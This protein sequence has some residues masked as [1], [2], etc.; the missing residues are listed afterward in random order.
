M[1]FLTD[2]EELLEVNDLVVAPVADVGPGVV[3]FDGFPVEAVFGDPVGIVSVEGGGVQELENHSVDESGIGMGQGL[4]VLE[5]VPPVPLIVEDFGAIGFVLDVYGKIV[6]GAAGVA[7]AAAEFEGEVFHGE[8][9]Q[10]G[11]SGFQD[12][13]VEGE[14]ADPFFQ[15]FDHRVVAGCDLPVGFGQV[16]GKIGFLNA[17]LVGEDASAQDVEQGIGIMTGVAE[18]VGGALQAVGTRHQL[19]QLPGAGVDI[20]LNQGIE[21]LLFPDGMTKGDDLGMVQVDVGHDFPLFLPMRGKVDFRRDEISPLF[22]LDIGFTGHLLVSP[23]TIE[24]QGRQEAQGP[25]QSE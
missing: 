1:E 15:A 12:L 2:L 18:V 23:E 14:E 9:D 21:V 20:L 8:P 16:P 3:G 25:V 5:E 11:V 22:A 13:F 6:P 19:N 10:V 7:M 17:V 4:P 24:L